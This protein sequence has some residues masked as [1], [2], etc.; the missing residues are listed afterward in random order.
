MNPVNPLDITDSV[1]PLN[2]FDPEVG[3][4]VDTRYIQEQSQPN[5][6][7]FLFTYN[8]T[9]SND[10]DIPLTLVK[11][12]WLITNSDDS[13]IEVN[14][15]GVVGDQPLIGPGQSYQYTSGVVLNSQVGTMQGHYVMEKSNGETFNATIPAFLLCVPNAIN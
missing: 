6:G 5:E 9:I 8:I 7:R 3:V 14:G 13:K 11:R 10:S 12:Y 2:S 4:S 15:D 1:S